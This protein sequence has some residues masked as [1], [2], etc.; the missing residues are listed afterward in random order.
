V[1]SC[2]NRL[3]SSLLLETIA[4]YAKPV[5]SLHRGDGRYRSSRTDCVG[6]SSCRAVS[7]EITIERHLKVPVTLRPRFQDR[8]NVTA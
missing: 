5:R 3:V 7:F 2:Y 1:S 6:T 8:Q 4:R